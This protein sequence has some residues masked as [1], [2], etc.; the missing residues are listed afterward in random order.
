MDEDY[1]AEKWGADTEAEKRATDLARE[2][3]KAVE[4]IDKL[5]RLTRNAGC[6]QP[7]GENG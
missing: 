4:L 1:Q 6:I 2:L 5:A 7:G 3:D